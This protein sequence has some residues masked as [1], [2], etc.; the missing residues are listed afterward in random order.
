[1]VV[2]PIEVIG[3]IRS[4]DQEEEGIPYEPP[5]TSDRL[6]RRLSRKS[7]FRSP[8]PSSRGAITRSS[9]SDLGLSVT[10]VSPVSLSS[11]LRTIPGFGNVND[12]RLQRPLR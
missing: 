5:L 3:S 8:K 10:V 9:P 4:P 6:G 2:E 11:V 12:R 1:M 7:S